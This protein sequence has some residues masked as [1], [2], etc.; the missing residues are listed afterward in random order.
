MLEPIAI[1]FVVEVNPRPP[2]VQF[3]ELSRL[4]LIYR[5]SLPLAFEFV[6]AT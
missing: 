5:R 2:E 4:P 3:A 6:N 1:G